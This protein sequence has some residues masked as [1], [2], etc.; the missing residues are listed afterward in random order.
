MHRHILFVPLRL[1]VGGCKLRACGLSG[2]R[3]AAGG[4]HPGHRLPARGGAHGGGRER[5]G[6]GGG[7]G[8]RGRPFVGLSMMTV[9]D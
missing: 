8:G 1:A 9:D 7:P 5:D 6:A 4:G 3:A 2:G